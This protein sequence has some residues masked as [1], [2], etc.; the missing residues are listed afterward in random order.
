MK[1][2]P[3]MYT[4]CLSVNIY[5]KWLIIMMNVKHENEAYQTMVC[6]VQVLGDAID[7]NPVIDDVQSNTWHHLVMVGWLKIICPHN[8]RS[9]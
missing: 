1:D 7:M 8:M 9:Y 6:C 4:Q 2:L 5:C 3:D